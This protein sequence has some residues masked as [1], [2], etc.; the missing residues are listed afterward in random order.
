MN[1]PENSGLSTAEL[2]TRA[3]NLQRDGRSEQAAMVLQQV[4]HQDPQHYPALT[5]L[6]RFALAAGQPAIAER[7]AS[8]ARTVN[9]DGLEALATLAQLYQASG[10]LTEAVECMQHAASIQPDSDRAQ[11]NL[12]LLSEQNGDIATARAAYERA[13]ALNAGNLD[14]L[15]NLVMLELADDELDEALRHC[16]I[17]HAAKRGSSEALRDGASLPDLGDDEKL[18]SRFKMKMDHEQLQHLRDAGV[19]DTRF[20]PLIE[21]LDAALEDVADVADD[22]EAFNRQHPRHHWKSH[23]QLINRLH[24]RPLHLPDVALPE[25]PLINPDLDVAALERTYHDSDPQ[26]VVVDDF[27]TAPAL[28]ALRAFCRDAT[29]WYDLRRNYLGAYLTDGFANPLTLGIARGLRHALPGIFGAHPLTQA[30]AYKYGPTLNGI[31]M[32]A[33]AAAVNC[34]FWIAPDDA[35]TDPDKGGLLV[36]RKEAPLDWHF[37]KFNNDAA[38]MRAHLGNDID[39]PIRV[40]H[41]SNRIVIFN[42]NLFHRTDDIAFRDDFGGRRYNVTLLYGKRRKTGQ[43]Q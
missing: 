5:A 28:E 3:A 14:A 1:T 24:N 11:F 17:L 2:M 41:R 31:G 38:A 13:V 32:H 23:W 19:L 9:P 21:A 7:F 35:N 30:W 26:V 29:I 15:T 33:D 37:D 39:N 10:R 22:N 43:Q 4:V 27:L 20:A 18:T 36:Y 12:G 34:N 8:R 40:P 16:A 6:S 25:G 42:S